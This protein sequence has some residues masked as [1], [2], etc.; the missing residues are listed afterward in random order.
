MQ[1]YEYESG[2]LYRLFDIASTNISGIAP[3]KNPGNTSNTI[4]ATFGVRATVDSGQDFNV[5]V[6]VISLDEET[7]IDSSGFI[8]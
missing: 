7:V 1:L 4:A 8:L 6:I 2:I 3:S 5:L